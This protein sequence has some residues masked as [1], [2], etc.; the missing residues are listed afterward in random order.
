[1]KHDHEVI[2]IEGLRD[3]RWSLYIES[4]APHPAD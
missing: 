1:M 3:D 4:K 2:I